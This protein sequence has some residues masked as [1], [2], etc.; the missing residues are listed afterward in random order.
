M[1]DVYLIQQWRRAR[2]REVRTGN[3]MIIDPY[4]RIIAE[5]DV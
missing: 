5:T 2:Q 3:V 1:M 4:G